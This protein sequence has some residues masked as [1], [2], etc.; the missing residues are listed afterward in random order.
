MRSFPALCRKSAESAGESGMR[1]VIGNGRGSGSREVDG[2]F[3]FERRVVV[4][5]L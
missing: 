2:G 1:C 5:I 4:A 3:A